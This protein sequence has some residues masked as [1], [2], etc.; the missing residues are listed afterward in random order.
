MAT[1]NG[2]NYAKTLL[3]PKDYLPSYWEGKVRAM[4][5]TYT[6]ASNPSGDI[7]NVGILRAGEVYL[8]CEIVNAALGSGVT[9]QLGDSGSD[10]R[11]MAAQ[12]AASAGNIIGKEAATGLGYSPSAD[13]VLQL[14]VGGGAA[15]GTVQITI[16]KVSPN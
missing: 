7:V 9:L 13:T 8:G 6:F 14:K 11:Y 4:Y 1:Y 2:I 12:S 15:T 16:W 10:V 3:A 5:E